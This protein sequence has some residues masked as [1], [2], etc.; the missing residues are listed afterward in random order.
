MRLDMA[1]PQRGQVGS[2]KDVA[3]CADDCALAEI[4]PA[5]TISG[6]AARTLSI[7]PFSAEPSIS[8]MFFPSTKA[9][10]SALKVPEVTTNPPVAPCDAITPNNSRT[11]LTE[12]L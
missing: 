12:T 4:L 7:M 1:L 9:R 11:T 8:S 10:A 6:R 2:G 3:V 5:D